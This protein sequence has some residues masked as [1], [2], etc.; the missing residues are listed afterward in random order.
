[1]FESGGVWADFGKDG[2]ERVAGSVEAEE[3]GVGRVVGA[4]RF[5]GALNEVDGRLQPAEKGA[6]RALQ[7][8]LADPHVGD[9][10]GV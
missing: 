10:K 5:G 4:A 3:A 1:M 9:F 8:V 2:Q 6:V 7:Q